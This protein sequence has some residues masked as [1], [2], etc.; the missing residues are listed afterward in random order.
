MAQDCLKPMSALVSVIVPCY[1]QGHLLPECVASLQRQTYEHW[2]AIIV[3]DGSPDETLG[4]ATRLSLADGR[5]VV[6][7]QRNGGLSSARN[8]ALKFAQ[9][10]YIQ[11]LDADDQIE[12]R[13]FERQVA[14]LTAHPDVDIVYGTVRYF[15]ELAIEDTATGVGGV[16]S[17]WMQRCVED[18]D[19]TLESLVRG[20]ITVVNA[21]L[22]RRSVIRDVGGFDHSLSGHEDWD[23]WIRC[24]LA[25]KRFLFVDEERT[26]ALVRVHGASMSQQTQAMLM[27]HMIVR[28]RLCG[29]P[30]S[31][32]LRSVNRRQAGLMLVR[33]AGIELR[34]NQSI[35]GLKHG[36][37]AVW[38]SRGTITIVLQLL[39][40]FL[41]ECVAVRIKSMLKSLR[42]RL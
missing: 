20:N 17:D 32:T 34:G 7:S 2:Q 35:A 28:E 13:K 22:V 5:I 4:I 39:S 14:Y 9:G 1:K 41:P 19:A 31:A 18:G 29:M 6:A 3:D 25:G 16:A 30:L 26:R 15:G 42:A 10:D 11:F 21:P 36:V 38:R 33:L 40:L 24:A 37:L 23:F 27:S 12:E 8:T